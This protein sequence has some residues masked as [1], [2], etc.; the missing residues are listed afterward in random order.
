M[1]WRSLESKSRFFRRLLG[2]VGYG[3]GPIT[4]VT[5]LV[6]IISALSPQA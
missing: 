2:I 5:C 6:S 1:I 4:G 3:C